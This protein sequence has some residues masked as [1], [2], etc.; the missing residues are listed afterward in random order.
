MNIIIASSSLRKKILLNSIGYKSELKKPIFNQGLIHT[1][2]TINKYIDYISLA[3]VTALTNFYYNDIIIATS[4]R[5]ITNNIILSY[6]MNKKS[7]TEYYSL[8]SGKNHIIYTSICVIF[9]N[10]IIKKNIVTKIKFR[11]FNADQINYFV[12]LNNWKNKFSIYLPLG[13]NYYYIS[14][15]KGSLENLFGFPLYNINEIL[16]KIKYK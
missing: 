5:I 7:A 11:T 6:P 2:K 14:H 16:K 10:N 13:V 4:S 12:N 3:K 15:I 9:K 1:G 8:L